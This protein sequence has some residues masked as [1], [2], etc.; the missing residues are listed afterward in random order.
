MSEVLFKAIIDK[1]NYSGFSALVIIAICCVSYYL[2]WRT[3][4]NESSVK[5]AKEV[6]EMSKDYAIQLQ[7]AINKLSATNNELETRVKCLER[8]FARIEQVIELGSIKCESAIQNK[9]QDDAFRCPVNQ[10]LKKEKEAL[11]V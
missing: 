4:H 9:C 10:E 2:N 6:S 1:I 7:E 8:K 3:K 5:N 11:L